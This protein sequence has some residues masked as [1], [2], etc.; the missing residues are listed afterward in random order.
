MFDKVRLYDLESEVYEQ[1]EKKIKKDQE[2]E[3]ETYI[4]K[5]N[6]NRNKDKNNLLH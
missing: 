5:T 4:R 3:N 1:I 6:E 2:L